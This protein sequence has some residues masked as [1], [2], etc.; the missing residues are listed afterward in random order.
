[1]DNPIHVETAERG[2][3]T[4]ELLKASLLKEIIRDILNNIDPDDAPA[5][6]QKLLW[7]DAEVV[8]SLISSM[9]TMI[10]WIITAIGEIGNQFTEKFPPQ[11]TYNFFKSVLEDIDS[12][13][14]SKTVTVY[15][16][17]LQDISENNPDFSIAVFNI[18]K[19][20]IAPALGT[21][22]NSTVKYI[23]L[24]QNQNPHAIEQI[25]SAITAKVDSKEFNKASLSIIN[26]VF[27]KISFIKIGFNLFTSRIRHKFRKKY[28]KDNNIEILKI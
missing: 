19:N 4:G 22:I 5:T 6:I 1:M 25:I 15:K 13:R 20:A 27:D 11:L 23:N 28:P 9:P 24:V 3:L 17:M 14:I 18:L 8:L 26:S 7:Q 2:G 12:E 21:G 10:N 16:K